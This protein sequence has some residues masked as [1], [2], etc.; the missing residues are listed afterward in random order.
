VIVRYTGPKPLPYVLNTPIPFIARSERIGEVSFNPTAELKDEWAQFL[1]TECAGAFERVGSASAPT[2][3]A[4]RPIKPKHDPLIY[5]GKRFSGKAAKWN[6]AAF[7][8][9]HHAEDILGM[10]KLQIIDRVIHWE[11]VPIALADVTCETLRNTWNPK[12]NKLG[13]KV[14]EPDSITVA[15]AGVLETSIP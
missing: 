14:Q 10:R 5:V 2:D 4:P 13:Q 12:G 3:Q 6:A 8:K 7:I 1:L 9:K 15:T 11:L